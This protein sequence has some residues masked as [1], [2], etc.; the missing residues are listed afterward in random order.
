MRAAAWVL[1]ATHCFSL[2]RQPMMIVIWC[3]DWSD[4]SKFQ[5]LMQILQVQFQDYVP[6]YHI[7]V[8]QEENVNKLIQH[9]QEPTTLWDGQPVLGFMAEKYL[10]DLETIDWIQGFQSNVVISNYL[11]QPELGSDDIRNGSKASCSKQTGARKQC[12]LCRV[13]HP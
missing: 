2:L 10:D 9:W 4:K 8:G 13:K 5:Y 1:N 6:K 11:C 12:R 3:H 7:F